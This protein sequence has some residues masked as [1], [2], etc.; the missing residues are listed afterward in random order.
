MGYR[1]L[2]SKTHNQIAGASTVAVLS[3]IAIPELTTT[4]SL[5]HCHFCL[6][7]SHKCAIPNCLRYSKIHSPHV[8]ITTQDDRQEF[9][10]ARQLC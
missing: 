8:D 4:K 5:P 6:Y 1:P 3:V 9:Y 2:S 10:Q 7:L